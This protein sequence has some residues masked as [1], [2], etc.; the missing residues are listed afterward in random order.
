MPDERVIRVYEEVGFYYETSWTANG[1][2]TTTSG[3][4]TAEGAIESYRKAARL[5]HVLDVADIPLE[6]G[7][8][9][10]TWVINDA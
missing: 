6:Y 1:P 4:K 5:N 2:G 3:H 10:R 7:F 8:Y 9:E